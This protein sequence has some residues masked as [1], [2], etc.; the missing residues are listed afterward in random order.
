MQAAPAATRAAK[1]ETVESSDVVSCIHSLD[2]FLERYR[3]LMTRSEQRGHLAVYLNG[4]LSGLERKSIEPIATMHELYR[5][6]LQHFVGA[7]AWSDRSVLT[8]LCTHVCEEFGDPN[9]VIVL[10]GSGMHKQGTESVGVT[11][12]W[13]GRLGKVDNCQVGVFLGYATPKGHALIDHQLYLPE[14]WANDRERCDAAYVPADVQFQTSW[15]I[16]DALLRRNAGCLPHAWVVGDDQFGRPTEFRDALADRNEPYLLEVPFN[17]LVR[18]PNHW[19]GRKKKW[20][21]VNLRRKQLSRD[22]WSTLRLRD[23]E[24]GP[25]DVRAF[26]TRVETPREGAPNREET[27]LVMEAI[28]DG[29]TWYFLANADAPL[30]VAQLVAVAAHRHR[31]EQIFEEGKGEVGLDHYEVR[32]WVGW[33]HHMTLSAVALAFLEMERRR[34]GKNTPALTV[35]MI[36]FAI[37]KLLNNPPTPAATIARLITYQVVR[38]EEARRGRWRAKGLC[39]PPKIAA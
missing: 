23:G 10:D 30:D 31:I 28:T 14:I 5:R 4:L 35:S 39:A 34:L 38:N 2:A 19:P 18:R 24:K 6:P 16:A 7:G 13:C 12:Q 32:S 37:A 27:L 22:R 3:L 8:E 9:G 15:Q 11:R 1:S 17:T 26:C 20:K 36:R 33:H 29:R 25:I 21:H